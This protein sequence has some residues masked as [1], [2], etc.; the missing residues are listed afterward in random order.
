MTLFIPQIGASD[1]GPTTSSYLINAANAH[2]AWRFRADAAT[3]ITDVW[4][5]W[6]SNN[7]SPGDCEIVLESDASGVPDGS[8]VGGGSPTLLQFTP[9]AS[10]TDKQTFT[11]GYT[12]AVG[13]YLWVVLRPKAAETFDGSNFRRVTYSHESYG[14]TIGHA[15]GKTSSDGGSTWSVPFSTIAGCSLL[16]TGGAMLPTEYLGVITSANFETWDDGDSPDERGVAWVVPAG[17]T[18]KVHGVGMHYR[19]ASALATFTLEVFEG[20]SSKFSLILDPEVIASRYATNLALSLWF[21]EGPYSLAAGTT[22]RITMRATHASATIRLPTLTF[23]DQA[24]RESCRGFS[25]FYKTSR[26]GGSGAFSDDLITWPQM[27]PWL[28]FE[29]AGNGGGGLLVHPGM[30]GGMRG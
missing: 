21:E 30:S 14:F 8:D 10:S 4:V 22:G 3:E 1:P 26:D 9:T 11:N 28:E 2:I 6:G 13:E 20:T 12:P 29:A 25:Q 5:R 27:F 17:V 15:Q 23:E 16:Y 24:T 18:C 19:P 7:G